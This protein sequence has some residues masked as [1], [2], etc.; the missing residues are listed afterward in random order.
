MGTL[1]DVL[2]GVRRVV[3]LEHRVETLTA[4]VERLAKA[5]METRERLI[6]LEVIIDEARRTSARKAGQDRQIDT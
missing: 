1:G 4:E 6:R 5:H 2:A 3:L